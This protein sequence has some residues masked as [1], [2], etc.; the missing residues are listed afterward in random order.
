MAS[1]QQL[2]SD[3]ATISTAGATLS[4]AENQR[5]FPR[6]AFALAEAAKL[7]SDTLGR[8]THF[9][10][11]VS[12]STP[13]DNKYYNTSWRK[14]PDY[15]GGFL[16]DGGVHHAAGARMLLLLA[17]SLA[18]PAVRAD[19]RPA[20]VSARTALVQEHLAPIDSVA[21]LVTTRGGATGTYQH[22]A[23][24]AVSAYEFEVAYEGGWVRI[25]DHT[26][27]V[28]A[29][30]AEPVSKTFEMRSWGVTEEVAAWARGLRVGRPDP[31]QAPEE[32][33]ADLE[34]VEKM[35]LSG[36]QGGKT[37]TYEFQ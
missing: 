33:L 10:V 27:T 21:A 24:S 8:V 7:G 6:W 16:L 35:F 12:G 32:A 28:A 15:Q 18:D 37:L 17:T 34:F 36:E 31:A 20:S 14:T 9:A 29:S 3:A 1:A 26:V 19:A 11:R 25:A 23:G 13:K 5:F 4:I 30:G 22:A 2:I